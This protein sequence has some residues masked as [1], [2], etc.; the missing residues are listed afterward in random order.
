MEKINVVKIAANACARLKFEYF[1]I[2]VHRVCSMLAIAV[3]HVVLL[4]QRSLKSR[5]I[6]EV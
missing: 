6:G 3:R 5:N 4:Q 2:R 1:V